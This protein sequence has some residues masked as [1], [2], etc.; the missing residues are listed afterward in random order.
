MASLKFRCTLAVFLL[1]ALLAMPLTAEPRAR[2]ERGSGTV[3]DLLADAWNT[4]TAV[5]E[6]ST[7][8]IDPY[9]GCVPSA[10]S[11]DAGCKI[12]PYGGCG[13]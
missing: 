9:G 1:A 2:T 8:E 6:A 10:P 5:W 4:L 3:W 13:S 12:D 7:C 11:S